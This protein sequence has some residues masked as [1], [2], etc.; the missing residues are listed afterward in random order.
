MPASI[1]IIKIVKGAMGAEAYTVEFEC[2]TEHAKDLLNELTASPYGQRLIELLNESKFLPE[3]SPKTTEELK[4]EAEAEEKYREEHEESLKERGRKNM[5]LEMLR[6][7]RQLRGDGFVKAFE[8]ALSGDEE[9]EES[10]KKFEEALAKIAKE[11]EEKAKEEQKKKDEEKA[12]KETESEA[13]TTPTVA[14]M[15]VEDD[16]EPE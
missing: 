16:R 11:E 7:L 13:I 4:V 6:K 12:K 3:V 14:V 1:R 2:E 8:A 15:Q 5:M 9:G 10:V